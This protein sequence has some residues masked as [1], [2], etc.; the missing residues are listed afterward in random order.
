MKTITHNT[1][2]IGIYETIIEEDDYASPELVTHRLSIC[3]KCEFN[4]KNES[5]S[6]CSCLLVHR[7]KYKDLSCPEERW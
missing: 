4:V 6:K 5:C 2:G 7:T 3:S 1:I